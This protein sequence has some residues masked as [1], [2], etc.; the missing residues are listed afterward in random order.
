[1]HNA[2]VSQRA[3]ENAAVLAGQVA[4]L[5]ILGANVKK[6]RETNFAQEAR[7]LV[8]IKAE[9]E[10]LADL[11]QPLRDVLAAIGAGVAIDEIA[12]VIDE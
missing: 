12:V 2:Y 6:R 5:G 4:G 10:G 11:T 1:M 8:R 3:A 9:H 7:R